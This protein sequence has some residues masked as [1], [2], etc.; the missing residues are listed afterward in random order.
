MYSKSGQGEKLCCVYANYNFNTNS[1]IVRASQHIMDVQYGTIIECAFH[2]TLF[3]YTI[4][5]KA[6]DYTGPGAY[7]V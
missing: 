6:R 5:V 2:Q 3:P 4:G 1:P 7:I